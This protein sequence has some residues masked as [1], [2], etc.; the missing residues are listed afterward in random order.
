MSF[1]ID[2]IYLEGHL[3]SSLFVVSFKIDDIYLEGHHKKRPKE[4]SFKIAS[5]PDI[6]YNIVQEMR[7][8]RIF[9][10]EIDIPDFPE[11]TIFSQIITPRRI[12]S[13]NT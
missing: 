9:I 7:K 3:F 13:R 11:D 1:K 6:S 10:T 5:E 12:C 4:V 8:P 2:S